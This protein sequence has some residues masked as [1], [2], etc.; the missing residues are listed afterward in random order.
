[1]NWVRVGIPPL[2]IVPGPVAQ[3]AYALWSAIPPTLVL[4]IGTPG[5]KGGA[6]GAYVAIAF[7]RSSSGMAL[8]VV[9]LPVGCV[10]GSGLPLD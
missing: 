1:M 7:S 8:V 2:L 6:D 10:V 4:F 5:T 3:A 9:E